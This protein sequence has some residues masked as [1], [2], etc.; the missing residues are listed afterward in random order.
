MPRAKKEK[1][2]REN[3]L[4]EVKITI[5]RNTDGTPIRK[6]F[7]ST[8]SRKD[9]KEKGKQWMEKQ[10]ALELAFNNPDQ[11]TFSEYASKFL[12]VY[13]A[14]KVKGNTYQ[15]N[16]EAPLR[17]HILPVF[18]SLYLHEIKP[19]DIQ[20]FLDRCA[21]DMSQHQLLKMRRCLST[22]FQTAVENQLI[23]Q[24]PVNSRVKARS[25]VESK[26]KQFYTSEQRELLHDY[27]IDKPKGYSILLMV[28]T[29]ITRSE[30]LGLQWRDLTAPGMINVNK[31]VTEYKKDGKYIVDE[32]ATKTVYR[33]REVPIP[34]WLYHA[35]DKLRA[36]DDRHIFC[37]R[38]GEIMTPSNYINYIYK[39]QM[40][41]MA[42]HYAERGIQVPILN[43]H[44]LRHTAATLWGLAGIDVYTIAKLGGWSDFKMISSVY[45]HSDADAIRKKLGY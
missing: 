15:T 26:Q 44:E 22:I 12:E 7:Y 19:I 14:G 32:S 43:C 9:A 34:D 1:P 42:Q 33:N 38:Y 13:V 23:P 27:F 18:G 2:N 31:A 8:I 45:G 16:F 24:N 17:L 11:V 3:G 40:R 30:M 20:R 21:K 37:N 39:P 41:Q 35:L 29:G 25:E 4:F 6:S 28:Y 36:D 5:G 10:A